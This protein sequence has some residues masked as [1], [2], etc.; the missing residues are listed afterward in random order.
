LV[1][2]AEELIKCGAEIIISHL[3]VDCSEASR[4]YTNEACEHV[5]VLQ[6][7]SVN[8]FVQIKNRYKI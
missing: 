7:Q 5:L 4:F 6:M 1:D 3:P 8:L 2:V